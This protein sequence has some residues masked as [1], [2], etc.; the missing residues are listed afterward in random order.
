MGFPGPR[1]RGDMSLTFKRCG[2]FDLFIA[3]IDATSTTYW[4]KSCQEMALLCFIWHMVELTLDFITVQD[5]L[6]DLTSYDYLFVLGR[7]LN[8]LSTEAIESENS[9]SMEAAGQNTHVRAMGTLFLYQRPISQPIIC[10]TPPNS[11]QR[12]TRFGMVTSWREE[13]LIQE[14]DLYMPIYQCKLPIYS[15]R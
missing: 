5:Y 7:L 12:K 6:V 13:D 15:V 2:N 14:I 8:D 4:K 10:V 11:L 9:I 1:T 3:K